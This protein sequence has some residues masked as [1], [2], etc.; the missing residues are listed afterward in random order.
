MKVN[1]SL[2]KTNQIIEKKNV[3][4]KI[5]INFT[6]KY[7]QITYSVSSSSAILAFSSSSSLGI[8]HRDSLVTTL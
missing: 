8:V 2:I 3:I 5:L 1:K 4:I 7:I 6:S